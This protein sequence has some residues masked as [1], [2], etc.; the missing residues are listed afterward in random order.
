MSDNT[1]D[2][3]V[4]GSCV[5]KPAETVSFLI[6]NQEIHVNKAILFRKVHRFRGE[7]FPITLNIDLLSFVAF[8]IW[9]HGDILPELNS[10]Y[11]EEQGHITYFGYDPEALYKF[12][13]ALNLE[14]LAD[15]IMDCMRKA[16]LSVGIGFTKAQIEKI[17]N[18][19]I[20]RCGFSLFASLWIRLEETR[21]N[22]YL[23]LLTKADRDELLKN[24]F[25]AVDVNLHRQAW[26]SGNQSRC[27]FH[28][29]QFDIGEPCTRTHSISVRSWVL[30]KDGSFR[31]LDE[32]R[33]QRGY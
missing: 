10:V 7:S 28:L 18:D 33:A 6:E 23:K 32:W 29:H 24:E 11:H 4:K 26:F 12:A 1:Q 14:P 30:D 21:P 3:Q 5:Q 16:H 2:V 13:T 19:R 20:I 17:Y 27:R 25:I 15:N 8:T 9:L 31:E 22:N